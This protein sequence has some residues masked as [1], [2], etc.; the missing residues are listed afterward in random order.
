MILL[1][2]MLSCASAGPSAGGQAEPVELRWTYVT[3][4][5]LRY[6]MTQRV[7]SD[8]GGTPVRQQMSTTMALEVK[9]VDATGAVTVRALYEAVA[10]R[11]SGIQEYD[12]YS[13]KDKEPP[14]EPAARMMSKLVGQSFSMRLG[15]DGKVLDVRG[16]DRVIEAM[17]K[18]VG[19]DEATRERAR[20]ALGQ[21]FSDE[22]FKSRMQQLAPPLPTEK[23]KKGDAWSNEFSVRLP[24]VDRVVY[25][26]RSK[27]SD[28]KDGNALI[29]QEI[30]VEFKGGDDK[31]N[32]LAGQIEAKEA[33]GKSACV[34]SIA[35]GRFLS[36]KAAIDMVLVMGKSSVPVHVETELLLLE[37]K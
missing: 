21:M 36:Q 37:K 23:V 8:A 6:R 4:D 13:E 10:A 28:V 18:G 5:I 30:Q 2:L 9:E 26:I 35:R 17:S 16:Y 27:L 22:A 12:Y 1:A 25:K 7:S 11:A 34:F 32:P 31:E 19:D 15:P 29:D 24:L 14:D 20:Q 33:K 3:G